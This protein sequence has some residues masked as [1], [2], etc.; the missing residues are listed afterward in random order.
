MNPQIR[1]KVPH[2]EYLFIVIAVHGSLAL[3]FLLMMPTY[4]SGKNG[5][6]KVIDDKLARNQ[7]VDEKGEEKETA[8]VSLWVILKDK[9]IR[10]FALSCFFFH[11]RIPLLNGYGNS[12]LRYI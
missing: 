10:N 4:M 12:R 1:Q 9:N 5:H 3:V 6:K 8:Q 2:V 11:F 7:H